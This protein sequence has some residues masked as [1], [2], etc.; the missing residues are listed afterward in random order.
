M[1]VYYQRNCKQAR[2]LVKDKQKIRSSK[3]LKKY[4]DMEKQSFQSW[5]RNFTLNFLICERK[6]NVSSVGGLIP[7]QKSWW[8]KYPDEADSF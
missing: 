6:V 1:F 7:Q 4:A 2:K 5:K 3:C 8:K